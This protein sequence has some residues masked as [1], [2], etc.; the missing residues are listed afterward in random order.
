MQ[1][2]FP[3]SQ[4]THEIPGCP[5]PPRLTEIPPPLMFGFHGR[6]IFLIN[7]CFDTSDS[8][9]LLT[10]GVDGGHSYSFNAAA[11]KEFSTEKEFAEFESQPRVKMIM[12]K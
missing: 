3:L 4:T 7:P 1:F 6:I 8:A 2:H 5:P 10:V 12:F 9:S 11:L